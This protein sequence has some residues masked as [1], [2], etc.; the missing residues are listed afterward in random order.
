MKYKVKEI[1]IKRLK[2]YVGLTVNNED[3]KRFY[4]EMKLKYRKNDK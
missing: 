3:A 4:D 2:K 1:N